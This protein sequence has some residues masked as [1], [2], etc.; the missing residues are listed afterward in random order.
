[1]SEYTSDDEEIRLDENNVYNQSKH[2][3]PSFRNFY[4]KKA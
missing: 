3:P 2:E 1:M 4:L